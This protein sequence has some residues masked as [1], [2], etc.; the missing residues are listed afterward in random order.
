MSDEGQEYWRWV[1]GCREGC[2]QVL[3]LVVKKDWVY[4]KLFQ[5]GNDLIQMVVQQQLSKH[6]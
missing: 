2:E 4:W 6:I 1:I 3:Y 5:G